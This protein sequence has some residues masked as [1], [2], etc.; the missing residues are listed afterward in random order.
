MPTNTLDLKRLA[1]L[2]ERMA[3]DLDVIAAGLRELTVSPRRSWEMP[4]FLTGTKCQIE[5]PSRPKRSASKPPS[6]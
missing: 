2:L 6:N 1:R 3:K 5:S 4:R